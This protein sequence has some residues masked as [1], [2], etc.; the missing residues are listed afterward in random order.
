MAERRPPE[1]PRGRGRV[2]PWEDAGSPSRGRFKAIRRSLAFGAMS[3]PR[4]S[5]PSGARAGRG[6]ETVTR[7]VLAH[8]GLVAIFWIVLTVAGFYGS[9]KVTDQ[10]DEQFSMPSS[11]A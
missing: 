1:T 6:L 4:L 11:P 8:K 9:S 7:W 5:A 3:Q 10:L 2:P